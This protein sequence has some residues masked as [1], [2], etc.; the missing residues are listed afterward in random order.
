MSGVELPRDNDSYLQWTATHS[1]GYVINI[2]RSLNPG[3]A[4]LHRASC[5]WINGS[6]SR[7]DGFIGSY[8]KVCAESLADLNAWAGPQVGSTI[9]PC[10]TCLPVPPEPGLA[11]RPV[12]AIDNGEGAV[13]EAEIGLL[14]EACRSLPTR[15]WEYEEHDYV[16]NV[17]LTVLN[18]Q[19]RNAT[20]ERSIAHYR[21]HRWDEVNTLNDLE[22]LLARFPDDKEGNTQIAR[23]LWGNNHWTR[24]GWLRGFVVFLAAENLRTRHELRDWARRSDYHKDFAGRVPHLGP[25]AHHWLVMRLGVDTV[26]PDVHLRRFVVSVI[27][28]SVS[29]RELVRAVTETARCL[30]RSPRE[31]DAA[32]WEAAALGITS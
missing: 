30:G 25:A 5:R 8:I 15:P 19:M 14:V 6:P 16:T 12:R 17:L 4:R 18:L 1:T 3:D 11:R 20:V 24:A 22:D 9:R 21:A 2:Q 32:I 26:K 31:L 23:Y 7:G 13:T 29:D 28:H 27:G 10:G